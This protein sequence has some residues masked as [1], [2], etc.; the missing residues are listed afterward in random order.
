MGIDGVSDD[1]LRGRVTFLESRGDWHLEERSQ[2]WRHKLCAATLFRDA[3]CLLLLLDEV[4]L[5]RASLKKAGVLQVEQGLAGG[6]PL[7]AM[8]DPKLAE[9]AVLN[10]EELMA[11]ATGNS[12]EVVEGSTHDWR[13]IAV[14]A[15]SSL[16]SMLSVV[17]ARML[18]YLYN[19]IMHREYGSKR[20]QEWHEQS[21]VA[22]EEL[23]DRYASREVGES[24]L[25]VRSYVDMA[26]A[27]EVRRMGASNEVTERV[28]ETVELLGRLRAQQI[29]A[30][31]RDV[32][33]WGMVPRPAELLDLDSVALMLVAQEEYRDKLRRWLGRSS[34]RMVAAPL[35]IAVKLVAQWRGR[36]LESGLTH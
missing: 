23:V 22:R 16:R 1:W 17:Q 9:S 21:E 30:A 20:T 14:G 11:T 34:D 4:K 31:R 10:Y 36:D 8:G 15:Q 26:A 6:L 35:E 7:I 33:H 19:S 32:F 3:G 29:E 2:D 28:A 27:L 25:S 24:G 12:D 13:L 5:G 18:V